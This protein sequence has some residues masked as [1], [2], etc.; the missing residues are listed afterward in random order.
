[1]VGLGL[2]K[3]DWLGNYIASYNPG[4]FVVKLVAGVGGG[5]NQDFTVRNGLILNFFPCIKLNPS[6]SV[7]KSFKCDWLRNCRK[8]CNPFG[9]VVKSVVQRN[10][11]LPPVVLSCL[12]KRYI[13]FAYTVTLLL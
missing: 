12:T 6:V 4:G 9:S 8:S 10:E 5:C 7:R 1:M 13:P 3:C 11:F 2:I